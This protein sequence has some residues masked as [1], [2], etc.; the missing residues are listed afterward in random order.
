M[1]SEEEPFPVDQTTL[2]QLD[3]LAARHRQPELAVT[4]IL[5]I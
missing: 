1:A 2:I 4:G 3:R 5:M